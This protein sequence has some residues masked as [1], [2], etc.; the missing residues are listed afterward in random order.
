MPLKHWFVPRRFAEAALIG[1][2]VIWG[3]TFFMV[4]DATAAGTAIFG[5][6]DYGSAIAAIRGKGR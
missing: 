5:T 6:Q 4:K 1:V 2:A 3:A